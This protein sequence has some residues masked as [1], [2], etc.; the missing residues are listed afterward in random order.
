MSEELGKIEKPAAEGFKKGRKLF[1]VPLIYAGKESPADYVEKLEKYWIQVEEQISDLELKLG[2]ASRLYHEL[3]PSG[4]EEGLKALKGLN[5]KS[6]QI[7]T[8]K[9]EKGAQL[10]AT[11][12]A[13]LLTE[14]MDWSRCLSIGLQN[15]KVVAKVYE[16]YTEANKKRNEFIPKHIDETLKPDEIGILFLREGHQIQFP[17]GVEIFYIAPPMLNEINRW[18]RDRESQLFKEYSQ[19]TSESGN[20]Q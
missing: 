18:L 15:K 10:E 13:D 19:Q 5:E 7:A 2:R 1:F 20:K 4:G 6:Y 12:D 14:F 11:E 17:S 8:G 9:V 3:I 16:A